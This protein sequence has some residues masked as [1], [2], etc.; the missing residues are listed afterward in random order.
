MYTYQKGV[1]IIEN[2]LKNN[3]EKT[4]YLMVYEIIETIGL[5]S[6]KLCLN[7]EVM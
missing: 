6:C 1:K 5:F 3:L 4:Y 7:F 2:S